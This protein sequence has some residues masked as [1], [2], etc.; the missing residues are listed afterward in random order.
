[1]LKILVYFEALYLSSF[2][3]QEGSKDM[4]TCILTRL[5]VRVFSGSMSEYS[6]RRSGAAPAFGS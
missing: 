3:E 4:I 5:S 6:C 1:V 2:L